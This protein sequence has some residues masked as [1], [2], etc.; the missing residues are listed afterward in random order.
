MIA[1]LIFL[2]IALIIE[3]LGVFQI[4][5]KGRRSA[6]NWY[7]F[8]ICTIIAM[9]S[10]N[11]AKLYF[12]VI[13]EGTTIDDT[14]YLFTVP[15]VVFSFT[16]VLIVPLIFAFFHKLSKIKSKTLEIMQRTLF[17]VN[18]SAF[19]IVLVV[20]LLPV[21]K[22]GIFFHPNFNLFFVSLI[23]LSFCC[24]IYLIYKWIRTASLKRDRMQAISITIA[25]M[26]ILASLI[27]IIALSN[28]FDG[29]EVITFIGTLIFIFIC[30]HYANQYNSFSFNLSNLA[31]Y[32]YS[33][34]NLP[35]L[36]LDVSGDIMLCNASSESFFQ[37][38][39]IQLGKLKIF[40]LFNFENGLP[41][42]ELQKKD[43][44]VFN[45][46]AVCIVAGQKCQISLNYIYDKYDEMICTVAIVTDITEKEDLIRQ[47]NESNAKI[48]RFNKELQY[49]V[50]RQTEAIR[51]FVPTQFLRLIGVEN[52]ASLKLGDSVK[53]VITVMFFD[54]RFF[55]VHSQIMST[56]QTFDFVNKVFGLAG[57]IIKKHN[58][59][60]DKYL[61]DA[62][63]VLFE[64]ADDAVQAGIEIY[65][66][67]ILDEATRV[68]NGIDG[69]NIGIG[70]HT[71]N[72]MLGVIGDTEHYASTVISKHVN[73]A[74]RI[75]GLTK[76]LK[77][78]MLISADLLYEIPDSKRDFS[79]RY[80]GMVNPAGSRE[81][82]GIFEIL[83]VLPDDARER[84]IKSREVFESA[85]RNFLTENYQIAAE[86]FKEVMDSDTSDE[87][88]KLF[89][90]EAVAHIQGRDKSNVFSFNEK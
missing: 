56:N 83:D 53:S 59:F 70:V 86:R 2:S 49:E 76:Q 84:R 45:C 14:S 58:G 90:E 22:A 55:S 11:S 8:A 24:F 44:V 78:G 23:I 57:A 81:T 40:D 9:S 51:R 71:G 69:I 31:E 66:T 62:A 19:S 43:A 54:I 28:L 20:L 27:G 26:I 46:G 52:I 65:R 63:M 32:V 25:S 30:N 48:E 88:A 3:I 38:S 80:L 68:T 89:Y 15:N 74:S 1:A 33:A 17:A 67:L 5:K 73:T 34:V 79:F 42:L 41:T 13:L 36:I 82:I 60:V 35:V 4:L 64:R 61:G 72:V 21:D 75:E 16:K 87:C 7:F 6:S 77:A 47:L 50:D 39:Y 29:I 18:F 85:V 12:T 10:F 37:K